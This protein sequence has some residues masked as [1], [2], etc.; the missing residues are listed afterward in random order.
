LFAKR[1]SALA[2]GVL[3]DGVGT[4]RY[5]PDLALGSSPQSV[6][7]GDIN[8]D[9]RPD[10]AVSNF[11]SGSVS[12]GLSPLKSMTSG[13]SATVPRTRCPPL[14]RRFASHG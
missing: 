7:V 11:V 6:A 3:Q 12:N 10:F 14:S 2:S 1:W 5:L 9:G 8:G 13:R 4:K